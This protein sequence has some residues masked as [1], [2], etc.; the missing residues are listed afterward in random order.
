MVHQTVADKVIADPEPMGSS[1]S[2]VTD[3]IWGY[4]ESPGGRGEKLIHR[5]GSR[6]GVK[7]TCQM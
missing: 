4:V 3:F 6:L 1:P 2:D 5:T 7:Q